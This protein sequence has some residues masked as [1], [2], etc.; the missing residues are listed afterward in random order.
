MVQDSYF[1][2]CA[3]KKSLIFNDILFGGYTVMYTDKKDKS[4]FPNI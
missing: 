2:Q 1:R 3:L 4:N